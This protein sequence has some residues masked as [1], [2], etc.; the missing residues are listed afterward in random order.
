MSEIKAPC[1]SSSSPVSLLLLPESSLLCILF[2]T[3]D[4]DFLS[5]S[6]QSESDSDDATVE[7]P[8]ELWN[9]KINYANNPIKTLNK[10]IFITMTVQ[11]FKIGL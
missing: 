2:D 7:E 3:V 4:V 5:P 1:K 11:L 9:Q 8:L 6:S 10:I